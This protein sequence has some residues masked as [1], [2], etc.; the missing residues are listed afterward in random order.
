MTETDDGKTVEVRVGD[1]LELTLHENATTGYRW[2][3]EGLN[4]KM[5]A[6]QEMEYGGTPAAVGSGGAAK[7]SL[8]A[9]A[10]GTTKVRLKLWRHWEGDDSVQKRFEVTLIVRDGGSK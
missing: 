7:W 3:F 10:A 6:A 9:I 4:T 8:K 1:T 2:T 5:I